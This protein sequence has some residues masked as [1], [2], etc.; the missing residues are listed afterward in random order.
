MAKDGTDSDSPGAQDSAPA[1]RGR[2]RPPGSGGRGR[3]PKAGISRDQPKRAAGATKPKHNE[4]DFEDDHDDGDEA[5]KSTATKSTGG[6]SS[7][8]VSSDGSPPAKRGRGRPK[9]GKSP[10]AKAPKVPGR[11]RGRPP[12]NAAS[13]GADA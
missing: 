10:V 8:K 5:Y 9:S 4:S 2:G 3:P 13:A 6:E 1:K 7:K 12:K 11:G